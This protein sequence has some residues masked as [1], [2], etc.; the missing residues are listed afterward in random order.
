MKPLKI[1][2]VSAAEKR[3]KETGEGARKGKALNSWKAEVKLAP[4]TWGNFMK[5]PAYFPFNGHDHAGKKRGAQHQA[6]Y[7]GSAASMKAF[8]KTG[9]PLPDACVQTPMWPNPVLELGVRP[10][11][12]APTVSA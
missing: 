4:G 7:P 10:S 8:A 6:T 11:R 9:V 2:C 3:Q 5:C 12:Y 1:R